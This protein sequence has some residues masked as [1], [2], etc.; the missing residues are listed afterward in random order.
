M[1][2][3]EIIEEKPLNMVELKEELEKI[4]KRDKELGIRSN[5]TDEYLR[6]FVTLNKKEEEE[7][8]QKLESLKIKRLKPEFVVKIVDTMPKTVEEVRALLQGY[9]I[10]L[11][12]EDMKKVASAVAEFV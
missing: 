10:S 7:L 5:K 9:V 6:D 2:K 11:N 4:R 1:G 12:Q 8:K 3:P